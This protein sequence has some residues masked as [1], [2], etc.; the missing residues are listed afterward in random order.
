MKIYGNFEGAYSLCNRT[1]WA[2][3]LLILSLFRRQ[4][5]RL[6]IEEGIPSHKAKLTVARNLLAALYGMWKKGEEYDPEIDKKRGKGNK[7]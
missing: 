7:K 6:I 3:I 4:S 2:N 1:L 5:L